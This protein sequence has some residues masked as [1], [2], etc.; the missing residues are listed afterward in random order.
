M[1]ITTG[2]EV[3]AETGKDASAMTPINEV[4]PAVSAS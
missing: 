3:K 2:N 1:R 4:F